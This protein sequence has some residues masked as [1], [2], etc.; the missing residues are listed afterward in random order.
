MWSGLARSWAGGRFPRPHPKAGRWKRSDPEIVDPSHCTRDPRVV[1][2]VPGR[3]PAGESCRTPLMDFSKIAPPSTSAAL[4]RLCLH[5]PRFAC[6]RPLPA[7]DCSKLPRTGSDGPKPIG[8]LGAAS[9]AS[10][11]AS[12]SFRQQQLSPMLPCIT[13]LRF[14][15][16]TVRIPFR[17]CRSSRLRRFS[18]RTRCRFVAPCSRPWGSPGFRLALTLGS[19]RGRAG[20]RILLKEGQRCLHFWRPTD[21]FGFTSTLRRLISDESDVQVRSGRPGE[22]P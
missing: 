6:A 3:E 21:D 1:V 15:P 20:A 17:P 16:A 19:W 22:P 18:P 14:E 12:A 9:V 13:R 4:L 2:P 5:C 11:S 10:A 8:E 7:S